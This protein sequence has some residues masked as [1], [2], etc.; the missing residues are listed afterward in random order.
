MRGFLTLLAA[1]P[2]IAFAAVLPKPLDRLESA[3]EV[4]ERDTDTFWYEAST[5]IKSTYKV[6]RNVV[7]D[8]GA[9]NAG[10]VA[11]SGAIQR[12]IDAGASGYQD[13]SELDTYGATM[14]PAIVYLPGGLY[15]M[16]TSLQL[17]IGTV[18]VGDPLDPPVLKAVPEFSEDHMIYGKDPGTVGTNNFFI[19]MKNVVIDSTNIDK[20]NSITLLDWGVSQATQLNNVVFTMPMYSTGHIGISMQYDYNSNVILSDL[21][22]N[23]GA[24]GMN[25]TG[26]QWAFKSMTF[27]GCTTGAKFNGGFD[28]VFV[29]STFANCGTGID[30]YGVAG[31]I[32]VLDTSVTNSGTLI[33]SYN[34]GSGE[35]SVI[36]E[37]IQSDGNPTVKLDNNTVMSGTISDTWVHGSMYNRGVIQASYA[38]ALSMSTSRTEALLSENQFFLMS[39]PTYQESSSARVFNI[40]SSS[41]FPVYGDG[42]T[43][44]SVNINTLLEQQSGMLIYFPA[45]T[46]LVKMTIF[47]DKNTMIIGDAYASYISA[48]GDRFLNP[49]IP[50]PMVKVGN[51]GDMGIAQISDMMFTVSEVLPGCKLVEVNM[52]GRNPGDVGIWNSHFR[53]G[54]AA[55]SDVRTNC[56]TSVDRCMAAWGLIHLTSTSSAYI[57]N[58]WGWTADHDLDAPVY[59]TYTQTIST[60]RGM[61]VEAIRGTWLVGTAF[62]HHT[63]YQYNFNNAENVFTAL[64]QSETPYWQG[65]NETVAAPGPWSQH[66]TDGDPTFDNCA[67]GDTFCGCAWFE[68]ITGS[69]NLFLYGGGVWKFGTTNANGDGQ[70]NAINIDQASTGIYLYGTNVHSIQTM[71]QDES[72]IVSSEGVSGGWGGVV[73]AYLFSA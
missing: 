39:A 62:E 14:R 8:F 23:G 63:L 48:A 55:G 9:D 51:P 66:L 65:Y 38:D 29:G 33:A 58:M 34:S 5:D 28:V 69:T 22:F 45:G 20:D 43:D 50:V 47:V 21:T 67:A 44:D 15:M 60:G 68:Q 72:Q 19:A 16:N 71:I 24:Y 57:E 73:A 4:V 7:T 18:I 59:G 25:I 17:Y 6:F 1:L 26:Q 3:R 56:G 41:Q 49:D 46:Y 32:V 10:H 27:N 64:Q 40:K 61:L 54:G 70:L 52:A 42:V 31:S 13:R 2:I 11:A 12:A 35:N 36:L 53:V 30:A 37:N